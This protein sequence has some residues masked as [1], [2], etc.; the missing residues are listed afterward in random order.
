MTAFLPGN[1]NLAR[2][3]QKHRPNAHEPYTSLTKKP[4]D[5]PNQN[6]RRHKNVLGTT[7][8][9]PTQTTII[10]SIDNPPTVAQHWSK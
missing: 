4:I 6:R 5:K 3:L 8:I 10:S 9:E 7:R 2:N 1:K